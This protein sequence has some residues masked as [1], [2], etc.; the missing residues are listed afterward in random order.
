MRG[1]L[2]TMDLSSEDL[3]QD[4]PSHS[5]HNSSGSGTCA[6][7]SLKRHKLASVK[8]GSQRRMPNGVG[9]GRMGTPTQSC[10]DELHQ[11][12][13]LIHGHWFVCAAVSK[14]PQTGLL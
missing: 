14:T 11:L 8:R 13:S 9:G 12:K 4:S 10:T 1:E 3:A 7:D 6:Q 5:L 2:H